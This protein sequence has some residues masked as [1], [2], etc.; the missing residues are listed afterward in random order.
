MSV[1]AC[2][3]GVIHRNCEY[4]QGVAQRFLETINRPVRLGEPGA[5]GMVVLD[6]RPVN[7]VPSPQKDPT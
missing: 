5:K 3:L 7:V 1:C 4:H 6:Q 2:P